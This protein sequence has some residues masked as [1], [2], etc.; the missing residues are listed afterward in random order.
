MALTAH[1]PRSPR[2]SQ[3]TALGAHSPHSPG[4]SALR[5]T[6]LSSREAS[7]SRPP[8]ALPSSA[9]LWAV[10]RSTAVHPCSKRLSSRLC[11]CRPPAPPLPRPQ[12][13]PALPGLCTQPPALPVLH[14]GACLRLPQGPSR[15]RAGPMTE[16]PSAPGSQQ[17]P[18][19][20][21]GHSPA[22]QQLPAPWAP[23]T[24]PQQGLRLSPTPRPGGL[25]GGREPRGRA[26]RALPWN[27]G[28]AGQS[29]TTT[30]PAPV[31]RMGSPGAV[32][33]VGSQVATETARASR[34][35]R[36]PS[37][38]RRTR[39]QEPSCALGEPPARRAQCPAAPQFPDGAGP[40]A[41]DRQP[42]A[43][44]GPPGADATEGKCL[45]RADRCLITWSLTQQP[46]QQRKR[47]EQER[48]GKG[49]PGP[50]L[51]PALI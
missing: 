37:A 15:S 13:R 9:P 48:H 41:G 39:H 22:R 30:R 51:L 12:P 46:G 4:P 18:T 31:T 27:Q 14:L 29:W 50:R 26:L 42:A 11:D 25:G 44:R 45:S 32:R 24:R 2:P 36:F 33:Q 1:G 3:P 20:G 28:Q 34:P 35:V 49:P 21:K 17:R 10:R 7:R 5:T 6:P 8:P 47:P 16:A 43:G 38:W 23:A 40:G 19:Q